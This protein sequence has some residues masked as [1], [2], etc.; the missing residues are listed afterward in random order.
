[1]VSLGMLTRA[2]QAVVP[3]EAAALAATGASGLFGA[4]S[5]YVLRPSTAAWAVAF[6]VLA[7]LAVVGTG[8]AYTLSAPVGGGPREPTG[9]PRKR[10]ADYAGLACLA[11][12]APLALGALGVLGVLMDEGRQLLQ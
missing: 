9:P 3:V 4:V 8:V 12:S 6:V 11:L 7:G 10:V 5:V 2:N 1:M